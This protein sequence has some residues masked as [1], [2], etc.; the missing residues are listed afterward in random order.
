MLSFSSRLIG[1]SIQTDL[2]P[3]SSSRHRPGSCLFDAMAVFRFANQLVYGEVKVSFLALPLLRHNRGVF[4]QTESM[5]WLRMPD[6]RSIYTNYNLN[7]TYGVIWIWC[8]MHSESRDRR[9]ILR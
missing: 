5:S 1:D 9:R 2:V 7:T 8:A 6:L 4:R 3:A